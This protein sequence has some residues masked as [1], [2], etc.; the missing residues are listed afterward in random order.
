MR[1][2]SISHCLATVEFFLELEF[3]QEACSWKVISV[4]VECVNINQ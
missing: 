4:V 2:A 3:Y 1:K